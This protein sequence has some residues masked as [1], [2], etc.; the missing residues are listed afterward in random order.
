MPR[1]FV[2]SFLGW[3]LDAYDF[4]LL[5]VVVP[6]V[7][8]TFGTSVAAVAATVTLTLATRPL[9]ALI[10]GW[11]GDRYGRRTPLMVD[12]GLYSVFELATAFAP[13]LAALL[14]L[15]ALFGIA[16]GGEWGLGAALAMESIPTETR[17]F[18]SGILQEGYAVGYLLAAITLALFYHLIGWRGMFA[19]GVLPALLILY[20]RS[21]VEESPA[22]KAGSAHRLTFGVA[23]LFRLFREHW[24][25]FIYSIVLMAAFNFMSHGTQDPYATFLT[26]QEKFTPA[27]VGTITAITMVGAICGGLFFGAISQRIG[28]RIAMVAAAIAGALL[29]PVW[30]FSHGGIALAA[31]G[32]AMQFMVQGAWGI[33]PAHLN[34]LAPALVRGTFPGFTYQIG[35]LIASATLQIE[36]T[37]AAHRYATPAQPNYANAMAFFMVVVFVAVVVFTLFGYLVAPERRTQTLSRA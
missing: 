32:F 30:V 1:A 14:V 10:F 25:L 5:V 22:W 18:Y 34:E 21:G 16:M 2:A 36:A 13:N 8:D 17:G 19:I 24:L 12:I 35:N 26:R 11:L 31:A 6:H 37:L 29:I 15:R 7:A 9:G 28:R 4:F 27:F 20:I 23:E 3:T 33:I